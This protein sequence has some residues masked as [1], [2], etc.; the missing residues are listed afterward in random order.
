M[1]ATSKD[2]GPLPLKSLLVGIGRVAR[3]ISILEGTSFSWERSWG[4]AG[5]FVASGDT[6]LVASVSFSTTP[7]CLD[8]R[9]G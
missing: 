3:I 2:F 7:G 8:F 5:G 9:I 1:S 4:A 6:P